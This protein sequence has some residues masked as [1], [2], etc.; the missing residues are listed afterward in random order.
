MTNLFFVKSKN[1][2]L[3]DI[4][5]LLKIKNK[6]KKKIKIN[7]IKTL[8]NASFNDISFFN[9]SRYKFSDFPTSDV[10]KMKLIS[11]YAICALAFKVITLSK[12][13][14]KIIFFIVKK[15]CQF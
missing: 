2:F 5:K 6:L 10:F 9:S 8:T 14:K 11:M 7:D 3:S 13:K 12:N 1:I 15:M 4:C